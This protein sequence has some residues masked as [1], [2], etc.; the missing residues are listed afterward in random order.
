MVNE[1][2]ETGAPV[3]FRK[4]EGETK[5]PLADMS[6]E[7]L[8]APTMPQERVVRAGAVPLH[9]AMVRL[10]MRAEGL[11]LAEWTKWEGWLYTEAELND[12]AE[13]SQEVG[14]MLNPVAQFFTAL[15]GLHAI[16]ILGFVRWNRAGRP[17][18][19]KGEK[20]GAAA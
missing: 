17:E 15:I 7:E 4:M 16:K 11:I 2:P 5:P 6:E 20:G 13:L 9:P 18:S 8:G 1:H 12:I 10:P 3:T 19:E 14:I